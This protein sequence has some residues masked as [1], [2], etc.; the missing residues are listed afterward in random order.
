[1]CPHTLLQCS[2]SYGSYLNMFTD[3]VLTIGYL[4]EEQLLMPYHLWG[5]R[6]DGVASKLLIKSVLHSISQLNRPQIVIFTSKKLSG[7][8]GRGGWKGRMGRFILVILILR[9][10]TLVWVETCIIP[11][12]ACPMQQ[13]TARV[14]DTIGQWMWWMCWNS[15]RESCNAINLS[16]R[17]THSQAAGPFSIPYKEVQ[18]ANT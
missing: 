5:W 14:C 15:A 18:Y 11:T 9:L 10:E 1:M 12:K 8:I 2:V 3:E 13:G 4:G 6:W 17:A 16:I 7:Q